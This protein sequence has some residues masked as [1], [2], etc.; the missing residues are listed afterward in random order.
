MDFVIFKKSIWQIW[1]KIIDYSYKNRIWSSKNAS[2][3]VVHKTAEARS[4][5]MRNK[6]AEKI[7]EPKPVSKANIG[8]VE[9]INIPPE[10]REVILNKLRKVLENEAP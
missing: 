7:L 2:K 8:Y 3:K 9:E 4:E 6:I 5:F 1:E 10:R